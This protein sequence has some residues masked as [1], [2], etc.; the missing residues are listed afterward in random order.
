MVNK[1]QLPLSSN[2]EVI[3]RLP[4]YPAGLRCHPDVTC[5]LLPSQTGFFPVPSHFP[6]PTPTTASWTTSQICH[7]HQ[8][9]VWASGGGWAT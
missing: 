3:G 9:P 2:T 8:V 4:E 7:E 1:A 5:S 6:A